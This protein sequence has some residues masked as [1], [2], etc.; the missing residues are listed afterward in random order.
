LA[1]PRE[2]ASVHVVAHTHWDR[3]WYLPFEEFRARL[4][5]TVDALLDILE[6]ESDFSCFMLDGQTVLIDDYLELRPGNAERLRRLAQAGRLQMGP[7]YASPD[8]NLV[9]TE[10]LIRNLARGIRRAEEFGGTMPVGYVPDQFSHSVDL[11]TLFRGFGLETACLWRGVGP[12]I[13]TQVFRWRAPSGAEVL[14][15]YL[16]T[17]YSNAAALLDE[18]DAAADRAQAVADRARVAVEALAPF[19]L[20]PVFLLMCGQDHQAAQ[21]GAGRILA[22][23]E[24]ALNAAG[25]SPADGAP[26]DWHLRLS[27]LPA[28]LDE[29]RRRL[30]GPERRPDARLGP[31]AGSGPGADPGSGAEVPVAEQDLRSGFRAPALLGCYSSRLRQKQRNDLCENLLTRVSEP[32]ATMAWLA[33]TQAY[34]VSELDYAWELLLKNH[35]HD[36]IC[37]C[38]LDVVHREIE[39]RFDKTEQVARGVAGSALAALLDHLSPRPG[40]ITV[41]NPDPRRADGLVEVTVPSGVAE[42]G[43][44]AGAASTDLRLLDEAGSEVPI[45]PVAAGANDV[46]YDL[47]ATPAQIRTFLPFISGRKVMGMC[48][49]GFAVSRPVTGEC[50]IEAIMGERAEGEIDWEAAKNGL[51][52]LLADRDI[53]KFHIVARRSPEQRLAFVARDVPGLGWKDYRLSP[54]EASAPS[55]SSSGGARITGPSTLANEFYTVT[56]NPDGTL[57]V[58]DRRAGRTHRGLHRFVDGGDRGDLYTHCPPEKDTVVDRPVRRVRVHVT[59][60]GPVRATLEI[61]A[62][63]RL[64]PGLAT[65]RSCRRKPD[66]RSPLTAIV[67]QVSLIAD[68]PLVRFR[69][70][71]DNQTRDHRL[72]AVFPTPEPFAEH[73]GLS[74]LSIP[75]RPASEPV[76]DP[77]VWSELPSATWPHRGFFG[78]A[79]LF[80]F[81]RGLPEYAVLGPGGSFRP[82]SSPGPGAA[83]GLTLVRSTGWLSREDIPAR[84]AHAGPAVETPE[85]QCPGPHLAEYALAFD[86]ALEAAGG[87]VAVHRRYATEGL[88]PLPGVRPP[89]DLAP[90]EPDAPATAGAASAGSAAGSFLE[91]AG[92]PTV[93]AL[94]VKRADIHSVFV[95]LANY[96]PRP[97]TVTLAAAQAADTGTADPTVSFGPPEGLDLGE[98]P[99]TPGPGLTVAPWQA[100]TVRLPITGRRER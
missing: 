88:H 97:E 7:W 44:S 4:V 50:R 19:A 22:E 33:G 79:G 20:V 39:T 49:N 10:S 93:V 81:A 60:T 36:S 73:F 41:V 74:H 64:P 57:D 58:T 3:E 40:T 34:P 37:G 54:R 86:T 13:G 1:K 55:P 100:V 12:E 65:D 56:V 70:R 38:S 27:T 77:T 75:R 94:A 29:V 9:G 59:E 67:T 51:R 69:T 15:A 84:P 98:K 71:F 66:R 47:V 80:V 23:A 8:E 78:A 24:K 46:L 42:L 82:G 16:A 99:L 95:R 61:T 83:L 6:T 62:L 14:T 18:P 90:T 85:G 91:L 11:P 17:S 76:D 31:D 45:Q 35:P 92:A 32:L 52:E 53:V 72:Q 21:A 68:E 5:R 28:Y 30:G 89:Q 96:S 48:I 25:V 43:A 87:P 2:T 26:R 63:Y